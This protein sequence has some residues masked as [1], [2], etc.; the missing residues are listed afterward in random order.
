VP[1]EEMEGLYRARKNTACVIKASDYDDPRLWN[2]KAS[3]GVP[4]LVLGEDEK[5]GPDDLQGS[6][7][8]FLEGVVCLAR[9][10]MNK[11]SVTIERYMKLLF[12][13]T[14]NISDAELFRML[15]QDPREF[16]KHVRFDV[17]PFDKEKL[18]ERWKSDIE[19]FLIKA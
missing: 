17:K 5:S 12:K 6:R 2:A 10:M 3:K 9:A 1:P 7:Y 14:K 11:D 19:N 18:S 8:L 15:M 16:S 13:K 4:L